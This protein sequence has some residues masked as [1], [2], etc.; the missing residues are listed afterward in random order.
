VW[1]VKN[2]CPRLGMTTA[3]LTLK[4]KIC[5]QDQL[6]KIRAQSIAHGAQD[7]S[8]RQTYSPLPTTVRLSAHGE[9][10]YLN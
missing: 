3:S 2:A 1:R 7:L 9:A 6:Q 5:T 8:G 4:G 10:H